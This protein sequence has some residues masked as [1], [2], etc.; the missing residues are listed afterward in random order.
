MPLIGGVDWMDWVHYLMS[1]AHLK[2]SQL[3][4]PSSNM[5]QKALKWRP[6]LTIVCAEAGEG[7]GQHDLPA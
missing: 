7:A 3:H 6:G 2:Y 4:V 5:L 1:A